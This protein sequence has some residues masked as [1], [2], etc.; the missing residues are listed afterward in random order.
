MAS[1]GF[2]KV[3]EVPVEFVKDGSAFVR[4]CAKP[5]QKGMSKIQWEYMNFEPFEV[6]IECVS[7]YFSSPNLLRNGVYL[8][9][10]SL[11]MLTAIGILFGYW[12][13]RMDFYDSVC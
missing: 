7:I 5:T 1:D 12:L 4:K 11:S 6:E 8:C 3:V 9:F 13:K 2:E 10:V